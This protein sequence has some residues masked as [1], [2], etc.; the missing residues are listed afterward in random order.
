[1]L[2]NEVASTKP[3]VCGLLRTVVKAVLESQIFV[4]TYKIV[5]VSPY[6]LTKRHQAVHRG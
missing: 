2:P 1:M 5:S 4:V 6:S 3:Y